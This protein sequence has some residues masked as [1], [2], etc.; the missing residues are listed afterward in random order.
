MSRR[1]KILY[2]HTVYIFMFSFFSAH[3][4]KSFCVALTEN[5]EFDCGSKK[6][7][8][9]EVQFDPDENPLVNGKICFYLG[10]LTEYVPVL[11][12]MVEIRKTC[13]IKRVFLFGS[14]ISGTVLQIG[15]LYFSNHDSHNSYWH[16]NHLHTV[17]CIIPGVF[18][19]RPFSQGASKS[20][21]WR[22]SRPTVTSSAFGAN[23][24][25]TRTIEIAD[26]AFDR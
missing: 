15:A 17:V 12:N 13:S 10:F 21:R 8:P 7:L 14:F 1:Y 18:M 5:R 9:Y 25:T 24:R 11:R 22:H 4:W 20:S 26:F 2:G 19:R 3:L 16:C 23:P 6:Y